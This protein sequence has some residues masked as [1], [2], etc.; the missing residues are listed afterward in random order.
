[1]IDSL[2]VT[3]PSPVTIG[4]THDLTIGA[5]GIYVGNATG[6]ATIDTSGS[7]IVATDQTWVNHSSSDFTIDSE[8]SGSANLT[9]RGAGSFA[10]GGANTWSGDLSIMA[11]GSVSVSSLDAALG[12]AT[13]VGFF[14]NDTASF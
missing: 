13:V 12:S 4:G 5:N 14:F 11:G 8:L 2:V 7:V 9:V 3:T 1:S 10:L 6:P